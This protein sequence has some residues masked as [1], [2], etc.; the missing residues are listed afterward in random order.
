MY[1]SLPLEKNSERRIGR[2]GLTGLSKFSQVLADFLVTFSFGS[3]IFVLFGFS[4]F[5]N[6]EVS[7]FAKKIIFYLPKFSKK[8]LNKI[9]NL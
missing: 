7:E 4:E 6:V 3:L 1:D 5:Q 8:S 9:I 2:V